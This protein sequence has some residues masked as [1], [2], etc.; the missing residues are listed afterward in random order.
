[1]ESVGAWYMSDARYGATYGICGTCKAWEICDSP[2]DTLSAI[3]HNFESPANP[4]E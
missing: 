3:F 4:E 2:F 1:M